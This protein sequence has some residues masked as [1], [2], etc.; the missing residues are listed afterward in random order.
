MGAVSSCAQLESLPLIGL[1]RPLR[2]AN[3][4]RRRSDKALFFREVR[5]WTELLLTR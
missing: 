3:F 2:N 1:D 4:T 5:T